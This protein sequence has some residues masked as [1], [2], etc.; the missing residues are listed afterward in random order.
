MFSQI[1]IKVLLFSTVI[2]TTLSTVA[3]A[4]VPEA[5]ITGDFVVNVY[6]QTRNADEPDSDEVL[7]L[8]LATTFDGIGGGT[9]QIL[10]SSD[11]TTVGDAG[12]FTYFADSNG[13]FT[14]VFP[15]DD[16]Q[17]TAFL[18]AISPDGQTFSGVSLDDNFRSLIFGIREST[19]NTNA[20]LVGEF[21]YTNYLGIVD[22]ENPILADG[23]DAHVSVTKIVVDGNGNGTVEILSSSIPS[24]IGEIGAFTYAVADDGT[25]TV[26][27]GNTGIGIV[28]PDSRSFTMINTQ[29]DHQSISVGIKK[30][31]GNTNASISGA[32]A[33]DFLLLNIGDETH[34][35]H[36]SE[37]LLIIF[38]GNGNGTFEVRG[39]STQSEEGATG[40]FT[41]SISDDGTFTSNV[42]GDIITGIA[43][44]DGQ[45]L[46]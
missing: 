43:S 15:T 20:D 38:D 37:K 46:T 8:Q 5:R 41:Y 45:R 17:N 4:Q 3:F 26:D 12:P 44:A 31:T 23:I 19:G 13:N 14:V 39:A 16:N 11:P 28:S 24:D 33:F 9:F 18:S 2:L 36:V 1:Y 22:H 25:F 35:A 42:D 34:E 6:A 10:A 27:S 30:S 40:S 29:P 7:T 32:Y 21:I